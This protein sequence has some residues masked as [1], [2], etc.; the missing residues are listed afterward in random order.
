[1]LAVITA[2]MASTRLPGKALL[3]LGGKPVLAHVIEQTRD[4]GLFDEVVLATSVDP[5]N[6]PLIGLARAFVPR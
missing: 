1:M 6:E 2:R 4:S 5:R 3:P